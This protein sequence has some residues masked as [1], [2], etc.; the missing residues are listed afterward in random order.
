MFILA[1]ERLHIVMV[2]SMQNRENTKAKIAITISQTFR[3]A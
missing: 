2:C 3:A 1:A